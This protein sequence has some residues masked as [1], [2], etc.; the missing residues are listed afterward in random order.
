MQSEHD[1]SRT[2]EKLL[3]TVDRIWELQSGSVRTRFHG[4]NSNL[5]CLP[6]FQPPQSALQ[7][8]KLSFF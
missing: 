4:V 5:V 8:A 7:K 2:E 1:S 3:R 6:T